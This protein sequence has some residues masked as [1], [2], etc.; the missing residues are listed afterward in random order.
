M[1]RAATGIKPT[2]GNR[3]IKE[4]YK[5]IKKSK[6]PKPAPTALDELYD[7]KTLTPNKK[8]LDQYRKFTTIFKDMG[9]DYPTWD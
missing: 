5:R 6:Q 2:E 7:L 3:M 1:A 8:L 4:I 9:L